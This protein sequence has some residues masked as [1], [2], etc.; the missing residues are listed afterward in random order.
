MRALFFS[1]AAAAAATFLLLLSFALSNVKC[2]YGAHNC[3][4][5]SHNLCLHASFHNECNVTGCCMYVWII[6]EAKKNSIIH[7]RIH[8]RSSTHIYARSLVAILCS[9]FL[10]YF[11]RALSPSLVFSLTPSLHRFVY[12]PD[13]VSLYICASLSA[14]RMM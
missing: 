4:L 13:S 5:W 3:C 8:T 2:V 11:L 7:I 6:K 12:P 1:V 10:F 9:P 14:S